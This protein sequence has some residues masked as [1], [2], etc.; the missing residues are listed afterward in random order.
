MAEVFA[1]I[2][3][4]KNPKVGEALTS[5]YTAEDVHQV[6]GNV[7]FV[8][9]NDEAGTVVEKAG[10]GLGQA[11]P[12]VPGVVFSLNGSYSGLYYNTLWKWMGVKDA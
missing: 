9:T 5:A 7:Y 3:P 2:L 12:P 4:D 11:D 10:I 1:V 6:A 8:Q